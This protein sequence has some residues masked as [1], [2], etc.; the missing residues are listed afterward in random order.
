MSIYEV[1]LGSWRLNPLEGNRSLTY[2]EL[3]DELAAYALDM[4][5]T[6]IE[7]LPVMAHP[8]SGSWGYQV[9]GYFAPTPRY[10]SPDDFRAFVDRLHANGLGVILDWVPA[11]FP[12]D[13]FALARF[14][15]TALYE[16]A[17]PRR[18]AHPTGARWSS[19]TAA[20][21]SATSSSPTP[22]TGCASTTPTASG[23]TPSRRCS[24]STTR[25]RRASGCRTSTA[26]TRTST[27]SAS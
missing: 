22:C 16:H 13:D 10:G 23:S 15:G 3:A 6:H 4:G 7:L 12:R 9:T 5:F 24:T 1:H 26:A 18:G 19:T 20:T 11:H 2:L 27:R 25:A 21:R 17:D 8:F 14:D